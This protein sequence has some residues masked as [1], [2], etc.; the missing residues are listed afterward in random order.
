MNKTDNSLNS[1][2]QSVDLPGELFDVEQFERDLRALEE[3][4]FEAWV[5]SVEKK[6]AA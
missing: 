1:L 3:E 4:E 5:A 6:E 2:N